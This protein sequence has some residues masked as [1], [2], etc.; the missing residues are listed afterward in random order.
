MHELSLHNIDRITKDISREEIILSHLIHDLID[1]VCCDVEDEMKNG[2]TFSDAYRKVKQKMGKRRIIEIQEETLFLIDTKYRIMKKTMKIS[3]I[4]GTIMFGFAALFKIQHWPL[5]GY[6][7]TLGALILA[8][9]FLP[10]ALGVLWKE[11][12]NKKRILLFISAFF[13]GILYIFGTLFKIQHWPAAGIILGMAALCGVFL[14][15]PALLVNR[16]SDPENKTKRPVLIFGA[17]GAICYAA[18]MLFRIMHWPMA[19]VLMVSGVIIICIIVFPWYTWVTWKEEN[20]ITAGFIFIVITL[21][22]II[23]PGVLVDLNLQ[24]SYESGFFINME[25]QGVMFNS[26]YDNNKSYI[27]QYKDSLCFPEIEQL[28]SKTTTLFSLID[29]IQADMIKESE[30]ESGAPS[31]DPVQIK[32]TERGQEIQYNLLSNPFQTS[33]VRDFLTTG[34][35]TRQNLEAGLKEYI[36]YL[37]GII[38]EEDLQKYTSM[39]KLSDSFSREY[40]EKGYISSLMTG[41]HALVLLKSSILTLESFALSEISKPEQ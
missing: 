10:S 31:V 40:V 14:F 30:G 28:H 1:H 29:N 38:P 24:R 37:S 3:G 2:L 36:S 11:T 21:V 17:V 39:L 35:S 15:I 25:Q 8:F 6:L 12:H 13:T 20:N 41:L 18:G 34:C 22:L 27:D 26:V 19:T 5:A 33:S 7:M 16:L 4:V 9:I 32:L 23:L